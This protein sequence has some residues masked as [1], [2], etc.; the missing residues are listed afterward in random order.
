MTITYTQITPTE[1][2]TIETLQDGR[3][4]SSALAKVNNEWYSGD[5]LVDLTN[6][7]VEWLDIP[8]YEA[9]QDAITALQTFK[10]NR[11][12]QLDNAVVDANGFLFDA[13]EKSIG[14]LSYAISAAVEDG[15]IDTDNVEWSLADTPTGVMTS[16]TLADL[17]L[18]RKL[19]V[20]NMSTIWAIS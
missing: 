15:M 1:I 7:T 13:D 9:E 5:N 14:R 19:A 20:Q 10:S 17:K 12:S 18:A 3:F 2:Q 11:Q 4:R 16:V 6:K 8:T